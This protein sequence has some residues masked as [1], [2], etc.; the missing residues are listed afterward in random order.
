MASVVDTI[1][2]VVVGID[3]G[4]A[5]VFGDD[6]HETTSSVSAPTAH[7]I[8]EACGNV[9]K[10]GSRREAATLSRYGRRSPDAFSVSSQPDLAYL[11]TRAGSP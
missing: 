8:I 5:V 10:T 2:T 3:D 1:G 11:W 4:V 7:A 6:P 9:F